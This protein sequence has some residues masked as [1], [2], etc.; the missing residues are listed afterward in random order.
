MR[1][2]FPTILG[3]PFSHGRRGRPP[4]F[5]S[6]VRTVHHTNNIL[7]KNK[8]LSTFQMILNENIATSVEVFIK[9]CSGFMFG[10]VIC[11]FR[12]CSL[13][14]F[15]NVHMTKTLQQSNDW[16][17]SLE[18]WANCMGFKPK[19][20]EFVAVKT[21]KID[22]LRSRERER[23]RERLTWNRSIKY[24]SH[25]IKATTTTT[26]RT[27]CKA[28]SCFLD[29]QSYKMVRSFCVY[30]FA[31]SL[32]PLFCLAEFSGVIFKER[33]TLWLKKKL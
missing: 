6:H 33:T 2:N 15:E 22:G 23:E 13:A 28:L 26:A 14:N 20:L 25:D 3:D 16:L 30:T 1:E 24:S 12:L 32:P 19:Y 8:E 10:Y 21:R 7:G 11:H 18:T 17:D 5:G 29:F 27:F 4:G 31:Q 9:I